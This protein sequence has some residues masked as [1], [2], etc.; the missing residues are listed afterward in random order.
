MPNPVRDFNTSLATLERALALDPDNPRVCHRIGALHEF[1]N[2]DLKT[3]VAFYRSAKKLLRT[4]NSAI[5]YDFIRAKSWLDKDYD[6]LVDFSQLIWRNREETLVKAF[7]WR[8]LYFLKVI[9]IY[10]LPNLGTKI[11]SYHILA[12][13]NSNLL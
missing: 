10:Y 7:C 11:S 13:T 5:L 9:T 8:G 12:Q 4:D 1:A 3:A 6:P 2:G